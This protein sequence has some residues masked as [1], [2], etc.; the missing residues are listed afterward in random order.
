MVAT[1]IL[2]VEDERNLGELLVHVLVSA[3]FAVDLAPTVAEAEQRL[4][5]SSDYG[6]VI[7]DWRLP[8]GDGI[9]LADRAAG[10]GMNTALLTGYAF[11][12]SAEI[13]TRHEVWLKPM[14]PVELIDAIEQRIG[15]AAA[16]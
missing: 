15:G 5:Q 10:L 14:R 12:M 1:R 11:Q 13:A 7:T 2:L 4:A 9:A 8:D 3:G 16:I 6:L